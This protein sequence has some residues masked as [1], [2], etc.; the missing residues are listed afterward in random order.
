MRAVL[1]ALWLMFLAAPLI[2]AK[3][4]GMSSSAV[5][6]IKVE[7]SP[8]AASPEYMMDLVAAV[9]QARKS[10]RHVLLYTGHSYHLKKTQSATPRAYFEDVM[11][12]HS[13]TLAARR[14]DFVVCELFEFTPMFDARR[15]MTPE[16]VKMM[17]G[18]FGT[19]DNRY[20]IRFFTPTLTFLDA[21]GTKLAGPFDGYALVGPELEAALKKLPRPPGK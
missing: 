13:P 9:E 2:P 17:R 1:T 11:L 3:D 8:S 15:N 14:A 18:W 6:P 12:K 20:D 7:N 16:F 4:T 5:P 10:G 19:L 21:T